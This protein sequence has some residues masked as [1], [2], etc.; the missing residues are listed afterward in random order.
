MFLGKSVLKICS[1]FIGEHPYQS[2]ISIKLQSN[3]IE[4]TLRHGCSPV[5]LRHMFKTPFPKNTSAGMLLEV[6]Q[7]RSEGKFAHLNY[8][9]I[10]TRD[11]GKK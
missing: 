8:R 10:I 11:Q 5:N 2:A 7:L 1:K 9:S 6:K 4:I 3:F